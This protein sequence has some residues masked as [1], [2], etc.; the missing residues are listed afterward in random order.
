VKRTRK[1]SSMAAFTMV[2]ALVSIVMLALFVVGVTALIV[3]GRE[4]MDS[5]RSHYTAATIAKNRLEHL[6][7][8][9][10]DDLTLFGENGVLVDAS[11]VPTSQGNY[12]RTTT[13]S[14]VNPRLIDAACKV[15]I[16]DRV[17]L[18][19]GVESETVR[20]LISRYEFP[21]K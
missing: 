21:G 12:R 1:S 3:T 2:E 9:G 15:D 6:Q 16:R 14:N 8:L 20:T 19:F 5:A 18:A 7:S 11:G 10:Y 17:T 13:V 4:V